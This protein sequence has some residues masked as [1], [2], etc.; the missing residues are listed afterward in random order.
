MTPTRP[1]PGGTHRRIP[2]RRT[3][4]PP[5]VYPV[6]AM[7]IPSPPLVR[8]MVP[9]LGALTLT[10][11]AGC[12]GDA[13]TASAPSPTEP[14]KPA[15]ELRRGYETPIPMNEFWDGTRTLKYTYEMR[16]DT[17]GKLHRNGWGRAY[18]ANG[19][20]EREGTYRY[21]PQREMSERM[22]TWTYYE[23]DGSVKRVE[24]RGGVPIWTGPDQTTAPPGT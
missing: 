3:T 7:T 4:V 22:G 17:D 21:D 18:Y 6:G 10:L 2:R 23:A 24:E 14:T 12:G 13:T 20:I 15:T 16:F 9:L 1:R 19:V 11:A 5:L 8:F